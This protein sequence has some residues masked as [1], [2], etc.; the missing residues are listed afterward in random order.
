MHPKHAPYKAT[1]GYLRE[2]AIMV[3]RRFYITENA[4]GKQDARVREGLQC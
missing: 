2:D 1:G 4:N 3:L